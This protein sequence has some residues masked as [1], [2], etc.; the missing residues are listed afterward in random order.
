M[1]VIP[2]IAPEIIARHPDFHAASLT[3]RGAA[4]TAPESPEFAALLAQ[5]EASLEADDP[6]RE[7]HL[8]AW[9]AAYRGFGAKPNR[10]LPSATALLKRSRKDGALPRISPLVDAYNAVSVLHGIP[11]GGEDLALYQ[12][13]PRLV[14]AEG[15]EPFDTVQNGEAVIEAP[16]K[17]EVVWRDDHGVTCRRWNWRQGRRTMI[18]EASRDL[19]LVLE[20]LGPMPAGRLAEAAGQLA[21]VIAALCPEA[22]IERHRLD[23]TGFQP[24]A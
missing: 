24:L 10:T 11:V 19:W 21:G 3:I 17:A 18:T 14:I 22:V 20:A 8:L 16:E 7:A 23:A 15:S 13:A 9:D 12:G 6:V 2:Q 1:P 5:A 4:I